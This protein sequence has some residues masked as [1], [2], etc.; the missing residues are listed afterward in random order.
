MIFPKIG[1]GYMGVPITFLDKY[2]PEQ[3]E[4]IGLIKSNFNPGIKDF[5]KYNEYIEMKVIGSPT[6]RSGKNI[7]RF[8]VLKGRK[9]NKNYYLRE[10][11]K[12]VVCAL[13]PR[14]LIKN[15]KL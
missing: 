4:I 5:K 13:Y 10:K 8:P 14:I 7:N 2:N 12:D 6:G 1:G 9:E 3:F 15:K 11:D